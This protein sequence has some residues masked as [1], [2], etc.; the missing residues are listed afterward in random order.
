[1]EKLA[2]HEI[3]SLGEAPSVGEHQPQPSKKQVQQ[4]HYNPV[5]NHRHQVL[6]K[7]AWGGRAQFRV[8]LPPF[9]DTKSNRRTNESQLDRPR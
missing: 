9:E 5:D 7:Q 3:H 4:G 1:M 2:H 6:E 8:S